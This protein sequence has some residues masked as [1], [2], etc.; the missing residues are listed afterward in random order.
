MTVTELGA[1][2]VP[3]NP[4]MSRASSWGPH[5]DDLPVEYAST[6]TGNCL[7]PI[8]SH[9]VCLAFSKTEIAKAGDFVAIWFR[10]E[11]LKD[12][13]ENSRFVKRMVFSNMPGLSPSSA[14]RSRSPGSRT[15]RS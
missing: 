3:A 9:G 7:E 14:V 1:E 5:P 8:F 10:P 12:P 2:S 15:V 13:R 11:Y 6:C 4:A